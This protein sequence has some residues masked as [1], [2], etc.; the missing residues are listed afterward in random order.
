MTCKWLPLV[1]SRYPIHLTDTSHRHIFLLHRT[2]SYLENG[3]QT[4]LYQMSLV[5]VQNC[6]SMKYI[7]ESLE[8]FKNQNTRF[9][10]I[11]FD[12]LKAVFEI[13]LAAQCTLAIA[14]FVCV[15]WTIGRKMLIN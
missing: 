14:Y 11:N 4:H 8:N 3:I 12:F 5:L 2:A 1:L 13:L 10:P 6:E 9:V 7:F 15:L